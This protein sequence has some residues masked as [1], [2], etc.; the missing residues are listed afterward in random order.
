MRALVMAAGLGTRLRPLTDTLPKPLVPVGG[1]P[2]VEHVLDHLASQGVREARLNIHYLPEKMKTFAGGWNNR[3]GEPKLFLQDE[4]AKILGS[5]GGVALAAPWLLENEDAALICNSDVLATPNLRAL[6]RA[7]QGSGAVCTLVVMP[8]PEAGKKFTGL[9]VSGGKVV[10]FEKSGEGL[11]HFPGFYMIGNEA[12]KRMP[13]AGEA[14][15]VVEALWKP[16][17]AEGKLGAFLYEGDYHDLGTVADLEA[18]EK[19]LTGK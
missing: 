3:G 15:S 12:V 16:L 9:R 13:R 18:A 6:A 2:M 5:G 17:A 7:H 19:F 1:R 11:F 10:G 14:F 8:H 4:S